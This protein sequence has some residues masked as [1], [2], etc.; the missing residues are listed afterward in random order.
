[1]GLN[2][3]DDILALQNV[4]LLLW[5]CLG[6]CGV[7]SGTLTRGSSVGASAQAFQGHHR[8]PSFSLPRSSV[9]HSSLWTS[10]GCVLTR[11]SQEGSA[12][13]LSVSPALP[14]PPHPTTHPRDDADH[15]ERVVPGSKITES[16]EF[17]G[18][19]HLSLSFL[20]VCVCVFACSTTILTQNLLLTLS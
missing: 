20:M 1:M 14:T 17:T 16:W 4:T 10:S 5:R 13:T 6:Q 8:S 18:F 7:P 12:K 2:R 19:I 15:Q 11:E 3:P 9:P